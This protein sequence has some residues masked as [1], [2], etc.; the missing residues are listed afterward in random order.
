MPPR[1]Q[2]PAIRGRYRIT[3]S[4]HWDSDALDLME[5]A[6]IHFGE[7]QHGEFRMI[8]VQGDIDYRHTTR[9]DR[10]AVEFSWEG[11]D[12]LDEVS[13]RGWAVV[14][15]DGTLSGRLFFHEGDDSAFTAKPEATR[16][17]RPSRGVSRAKSRP[18][19]RK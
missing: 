8:A 19:S 15:D 10:P 12:E 7:E 11:L 2:R 16:A 6:F 17:R 13:G 4:E 1:T 3:S 5:P 9:E 18:R 14:D